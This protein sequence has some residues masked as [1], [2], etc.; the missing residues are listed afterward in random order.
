MRRIKKVISEKDEI[1]DIVC[2][3]CG[4]SIVK[5]SSGNFFDHLSITKEWGYLSNKD[6][7][8][9]QF[10]LC[11]DCYNDFIYKFKIKCF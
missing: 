3:M 5:S 4:E 6:G 9:H 11:E 10:D 7:Q 1:Y 8:V 2:N